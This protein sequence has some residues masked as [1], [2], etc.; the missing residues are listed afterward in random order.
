MAVKNRFQT[1]LGE[2]IAKEEREITLIEIEEATGISRQTL[3]KYR[4]NRMKQVNLKVIEDLC[5]Y[6][7]CDLADFLYID[8]SGQQPEAQR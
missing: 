8:R 2:K 5:N 4:R 6:F 1:L 3:D 7:K